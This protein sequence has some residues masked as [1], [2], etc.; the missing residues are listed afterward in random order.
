DDGPGRTT[1]RRCPRRTS[2]VSADPWSVRSRGKAPVPR[3][4]ERERIAMIVLVC[5]GCGE[6]KPLMVAQNAGVLVGEL[7]FCKLACALAYAKAGDAA[8]AAGGAASSS[9]S[10][11]ASGTAPSSFSSAADGAAPSSSSSA[12]SGA[13]LP[14]LSQEVEPWY[15][16]LDQ[17]LRIAAVE[18]AGL[19]E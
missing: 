2:A 3:R 13:A 16:G 9:S 6:K 10:A 18:R 11:A 12:G 19:S 14:A 1:R 5:D 7:N 17:V 4:A 8:A 15:A